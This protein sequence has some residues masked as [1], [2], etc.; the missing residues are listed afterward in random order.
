MAP[1]RRIAIM[2]IDESLSTLPTFFTTPSQDFWCGTT[3]GNSTLN[4]FYCK[5]G[6]DLMFRSKTSSEQG[7]QIRL[8]TF[9]EVGV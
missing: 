2:V 3:R 5:G 1:N 7:R 4:A 6:R 8:Y 9:A